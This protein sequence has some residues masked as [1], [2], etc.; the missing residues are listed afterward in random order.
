MAVF[1]TPT[2]PLNVDL[3]EDDEIIALLININLAYP[4]CCHALVDASSSYTIGDDNCNE[5]FTLITQ[6]IDKNAGLTGHSN[7]FQITHK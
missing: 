2:P 3:M 1:P 4:N 7:K 5:T 6:Y